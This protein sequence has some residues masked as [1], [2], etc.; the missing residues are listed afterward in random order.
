[1]LADVLDLSDAAVSSGLLV[2]LPLARRALARLWY[3]RRF[4]VNTADF[5]TLTD[6]GLEHPERVYYSPAHWGTLRRA[7]PA[8]DVGEH[9]VFLD[10]GAGKG[11]MM[12]E[13]ASGYAFKRVIGVELSPELTEVTRRN[14]AATRLRLRARDVEVVQSDVLDYDIPDDVSVVFLNN[15]FRGEIFASAVE[16]LLASAGRAPRPITMIYFN[17]VEE[18][19]LLQT[20]RFQHVRTVVPRWRKVEGIYG[21]TRVYKV[22]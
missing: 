11:R 9:D 22:T 16:R 6:L 1:M 19:H 18:P 14:L 5:A 12:L 8:R 15:P 17:P 7:L 10:L 13:A 20:G 21:T 4:G 2:Q 3:D